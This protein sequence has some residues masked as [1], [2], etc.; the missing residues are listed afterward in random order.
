[1]IR[2]HITGGLSFDDTLDTIRSSVAAG[3]D[4]IQVREKHLPARELARWT[5]AVVEA[6]A[7]RAKVLVNTRVDVALACGAAGVH[8]PGGAPPP[9]AWRALV[10]PGFLFGVSCHSVEEVRESEQNDADFA[11]F[12]PV[13]AP[14]SKD[15]VLPPQGLDRLAEAARAVRIPV[16]ALG[17]ITWENVPLCLEAG[18]TGVAGITLF[19]SAPTR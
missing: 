7:G 16:L 11:V 8:L 2:Y 9:S 10:P 17:G 15:S 6:A 5:T 4:W 1:L 12:A 19:R 13:F 18:A 3:V 14:L